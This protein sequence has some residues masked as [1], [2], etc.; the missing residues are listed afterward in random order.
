MSTVWAIAF[1]SGFMYLLVQFARQENVQDE[2]EDAIVDVEARL[3]WARTRTTF[4]FGMKAQLE[5]CGTLL[6][7]SKAL[8][9]QNKW[10]QAYRVVLQSQEAMNRAQRI[11]SSMLKS[12]RQA[13]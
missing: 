11:Y 4:P 2:Y 6:D 12:R 7:K 10:Q 9:N 1:F 8:W 3:D 13:T 5:V